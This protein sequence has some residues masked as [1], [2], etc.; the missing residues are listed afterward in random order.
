MD[1]PSPCRSFSCQHRVLNRKFGEPGMTA[2]HLQESNGEADKS[3]IY[4]QRP[5]ASISKKWIS[6]VKTDPIISWGRWAGGSWLSATGCAGIS[7]FGPLLVFLLW[8]ALED[9]NGSLFASLSAFWAKGL[10]P[11]AVRFAPQPSVK[12]CI[13][14]VAWLF[15]QATLYAVLPGKN[16]SGQLT[17]AGN[18]LK[19]NTNGLFAWVVTHLLAVMAAISGILDPAM[20]AKHWEGL[21]V[22]ANIYG[23]L[24]SAFS[25]L[26]A[27]I[28]PT[29]PEDRKFSGSVLYDFYMGIE[30]N[31]R[32]GRSW[33]FKL[34]HIGRPGLIAW[35]LIDLSYVAWQYQLHGFV[36]NSI[37][38]VS[39]LHAV[40]ALDFFINEDWYLRTIDI[41][42]DH[43]GF[44]LAWGSVVWIPTIYT[45][46][47]QYLAR[48][49]VKL[50]PLSATIILLTGLGGYAL[51][52]SVN[53]QKDI[54][55]RTN[56]QCEIWGKKAEYI[57]C[58]F[59]TQDG[60]NHESLLLCSGWW[61]MVRHANYVGDL[62]LS[63]AMCA[64]CGTT[65][66]LPWTYALF[67]TLL[68]MHRCSR[69]EQR[70]LEK[71]GEDW[72]AYREIVRWRL[73]PGI[74]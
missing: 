58:K 41:C 19:Y 16:S 15:F 14:Y 56:G 60:L 65:H 49:P 50:S 18:L 26:K 24:L 67:M 38:I 25:Y 54:F 66:L 39:I 68:L 74:F 1:S 47:V 13:G 51:F 27:Y 72:K 4:T 71:Y 3:V 62:V 53:H 29:H 22:A 7:I 69:D 33:D 28:A 48:Y 31:P 11:F 2:D 70:C 30:L 57:S 12:A 37:I 32:F 20:L 64:P 23:L 34:F 73:I 45:V 43:F 8:I 52:R 63:Y 61:G 5:Q 21:L 6:A 44:Y 9:F 10:I 36:T 46:Q 55:R 59:K 35:T 17:P 40:Y 42:H